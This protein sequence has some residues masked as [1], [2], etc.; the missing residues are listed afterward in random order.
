MR[1]IKN[2]YL[3]PFLIL[4]YSA[5][6]RNTY[7]VFMG[8][9]LSAFFAFVF[10]VLLVRNLSVADFGYFSAFISLMI[11]VSDLS[12]IGIG[13]SLSSFLPLMESKPDRLQSFLKT[14]FILQLS[15]SVF[16]LFTLM[17]SAPWISQILFHS[18]LF[19]LHVRLIGLAI[20]ATIMSNFALYTLIARQ[21]FMHNALLTAV[22]GVVR[23]LLLLILIS[24]FSVTLL[25][26]IQLQLFSQLLLVSFAYLLVK[27][28]F[29]KAKTA[30]GDLKKLLSF[31]VYLGIARG[32]T[33]LSSRLDV[34]MIISLKNAT[35]AGIYAI[36]ARVISIYPLLSGSFSAVLAPKLSKIKNKGELKKFL[37]KII[38]A[39]GVLTLSALFMIV[40]SE[41]FITVLFGEKA[42]GAVPVF[43]LLL[44]SMLFFVAS[45]P[46]VS[47]SIYYLKKP[48]ILTINA[49]LQLFIVFF[50]NLYFIPRYG[51]F[52][53]A[54]SLI[55]SY[56]ITLV[57]TS[58]MAYRQLLRH[59][60]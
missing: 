15:I 21:K 9:F 5:T 45:V 36:A 53:A 1:Q 30:P 39:T 56:S 8:N 46:A 58:I 52:G 35:E 40:V 50:G 16:V 3:L 31:T 17:I 2:Q 48:Q 4:L 27:F 11:L 25:K 7:A 20:A 54:Y 26:T 38:L 60:V 51:S 43:R 28:N 57:L 44:I 55:L 12:D 34:L 59:H 41:S 10:T 42:A 14:S 22:G 29:L 24:V 23:L 47:L 32:L 6:A 37:I 19:V 13:S 18:Q 49:V 33:A